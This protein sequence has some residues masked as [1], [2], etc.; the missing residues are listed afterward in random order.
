MTLFPVLFLPFSR[1][2]Y[3]CTQLEKGMKK[4]VLFV[5]SGNICRSP[6]AE[7]VFTKL[8]EENGYSDYF[9]IDS[10]GI[11]GWHSGEKADP[12]MRKHAGKRNYH[13]TSIARKFD[14]GTDFDR[15]D[16]IIAMDDE[17]LHDLKI[18][19]RNKEDKAKIV[20]MTTFSEKFSY[21][22]IPDPYYG[23]E[24]GFELVLDLL[25]DA[26]NGLFKKLTGEIS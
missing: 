3:L 10:A 19:A 13:L 7:G 17:N 15:F 14:P 9:H 11:G 6:A 1:I 24:E 20:K 22:I 4:K 12:R 23:G 25:E 16:L 21:N 2:F 5:C 8:V 26:C 18:R